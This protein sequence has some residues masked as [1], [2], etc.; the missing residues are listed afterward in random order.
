MS[1]SAAFVVDT[2]RS[3]R[4]QLRPVSVRDVRLTDSFWQPRL[5]TTR[6]VTIHSQY[7]HCGK[8]GRI[9][10]FRRAS[11]RKQCDFVGIYFNDSDV[12]KWLEAASWSLASDP[13]DK[14]R[15]T[16]DRV[17]DEVAAAQQ[18]DGYLNT[19]FMV[20]LAKERWS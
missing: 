15:A 11:G 13:D 19:Y 3:P 1:N 18:P 7:A 9:D 6:Q 12:Y 16:V 8:T 5:R 2:S 14:L 4:A 10:N 20:D 17:I